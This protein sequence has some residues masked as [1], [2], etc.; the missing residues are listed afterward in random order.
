MKIYYS[1]IIFMAIALGSKAQLPLNGKH[2][3]DSI[4]LS[5]K[6]PA[7]DSAKARSCFRLTDYFILSEDTVKARQYLHL[8]LQYS[9]DNKYLQSVSLV[10][11]AGVLPGARPDSAIKTYL[12]AEKE[13]KKYNT[14]DAFLIRAK[15]WH[16]YARLLQFKNDNPE[17]YVD[18]LLNKALPL[19]QQAGDLGYTG[20]IYLD[21]AFAFKNL[22]N[23]KKAEVYLFKAIST[24]KNAPEAP[25][26]LASAYHTLSEN[27]SLSGKAKQ[28]AAMLDSMRVL[29]T[30]YPE[31]DDWLDYYA[32][33]G[34]RL[35]IAGQFD[36][37]LGVID[38]GIELAQKLKQ[39]YPEQRLLMQKFYALYNKKAFQQAKD[40]ALDLTHRKPFMNMA[41]N[42]SQLFYCLAL[43]DEELKDKAGAYDWMK[44]YSALSDSISHSTLETKINSLEIKYQTAQKQKKITELEAGRQ[45]AVFTNWLLGIASIM[46]LVILASL[47]FYYRNSKKLAQQKELNYQQQLKDI[48]QRQKLQFTQAMLTGEEQER[49]R[50][51]RDLHDGLG[52]MLSGIK[53]KLSGQAKAGGHQELDGVIQQLDHSV[54]ELRRIAR[55]MMPESLLRL[56]LETAL[57]DLCESLMSDQTQI[58]FQAYDIR[59]DMTAV[60]QANIYRIVQELL[61]NAVRHARASK[62]VLQCSQNAEIFLITIED[63][64]IGFDTVAGLKAEGIGFSN[65]KNRVD[66][67]KGKMDIESV[68]N[69]GTIINIELN[70]AG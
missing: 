41:A 45:K 68:I 49:Q 25:Q 58:K 1:F 2:Y 5:L 69:E 12:E 57:R 66:Y 28:A 35:T 15:G 64:G 20:K 65:I 67:M 14:R 44:R 8:G 10:F 23:F 51:A 7:P 16:D 52:G 3:A 11:N 62:I 31:A 50:V 39:E 27:Y 70:A 26:Y 54:T 4:Q 43:T 22:G 30:P 42:R 13:L 61:S 36:Q 38:K 46:L 19:A 56:G 55:N 6:K 32:G 60:I 18:I 21:V 33:E 47:V 53:I 9:K 24:L 29:L 17:A 59:K 63:N 34:M 40:V 37:S 48:E